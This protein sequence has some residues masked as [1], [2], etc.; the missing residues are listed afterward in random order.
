MNKQEKLLRIFCSVLFFAAVAAMGTAFV[1]TSSE[2]YR[3]LLKPALQPP[4]IVF[5][6]VWTVLYALLAASLC[7]VSITPNA[8]KKTLALYVLTGVLNVLW[9]YTFFDLRNPSGA[10]FVLSLI[11]IAAIALFTNVYHFNRTASYL[12]IPY[13]IW[14]CFALYLNYELAFF[15]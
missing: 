6:I 10:V 1:D 13:L 4:S 14:L 7:L 3:S 5:P 8:Q 15:N 9:T 2:W 12:V 11:I